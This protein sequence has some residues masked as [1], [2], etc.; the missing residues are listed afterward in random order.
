MGNIIP[1]PHVIA[2]AFHLSYLFH[3]AFDCLATHFCQQAR[4]HEVIK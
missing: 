3:K 2:R 1:Y 4:W